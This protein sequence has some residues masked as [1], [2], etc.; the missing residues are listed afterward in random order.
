[1][2]SPR[3][4]PE[5]WTW[6]AHAWSYRQRATAWDGQLPQR[7]APVDE[8]PRAGGR[9]GGDALQRLLTRAGVATVEGT[10]ADREDE[11]VRRLVGEQGEVLGGHLP[12]LE[13]T[14]GDEVGGGGP[15]SADGGG[16][17]V[18]GEHVTGHEAPS[19]G[20]GGRSGPAPD[21]DNA[22]VVAQRQCG[23]DGLQAG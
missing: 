4:L 14:R 5:S 15:G 9:D 3:R 16:G 21:L 1:M 7:V 13:A 19:D 18:D 23:D 12:D 11:V 17:A 8:Q 22:G 20:P 10:H 6:R 2:L